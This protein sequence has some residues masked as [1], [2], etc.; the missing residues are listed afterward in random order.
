MLERYY[1]E[2]LN[3]C[4]RTLRNRDAAAD[5]VQE[6]YA[7]VLA[8]Q[9]SGQ[10]VPE[11]RALLYRTARNLQ[12]DQYRRSEVRGEAL[13]TD[14]EASA[15]ELDSLAAPEACEPD[16]AASSAQGVDALLAVIDA[17]PLRCREAFILHKFDGLPHSE[18]AELMG[19]SRKMVEQ[20]IKLAL[21]ACRR[22]RD[23]LDGTPTAAP[24]PK[25]R[26]RKPARE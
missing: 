13:R 18:V 23:A 22:C 21:D 17:L 14:A 16:A 25:L 5:I 12:V 1:Q 15:A 8:V 6:S 19:I 9:H 11:P 20:H 3:F 24:L 10:A 7:R 4:S 2:L 26:R